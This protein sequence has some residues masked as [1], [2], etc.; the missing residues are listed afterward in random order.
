M[1]L[2]DIEHIVF[3]MLENRSFDHMLG[4]LSLEETPDPLP[5]DGLRSDDAWK[6]STANYT[7][8]GTAHPVN[9]I[10]ADEKISDPPHGHE[11]VPAQIATPVGVPGPRRMGG[12]VQAYIDSRQGESPPRRAGAVMGYYDGNGVWAYDSLARNYCV[13][14]RWFT[15]LPTGTQPNRLMAMGGDTRI[16]ENSGLKIPGHD[17]VYDWL[18]RNGVDWRVYTWGGYPPF[19][20]LMWEWWDDVVASARQRF[21]KFGRLREDWLSGEAVPSLLFIEPK[22]S[23]IP[24]GPANDDHAPTRI[25]GG[26]NLVK[27]LYDI[28]TSNAERWAKTLLIVTYDE[29]GGFFDHVP[30]LPIRKQVAE[31]LFETTGPRVPALLIS[32][33]V[34]PGQVFHEPV[35]HTAFLALLAERFTPGVPYSGAVA[36]RQSS[37]AGFGRLSQALRPSARAGAAPRI[38]RPLAVSALE[39]LE[40]LTGMEPGRMGPMDEAPDADTPTA[41]AFDRAAR[42]TAEMHPDLLV[43]PD[44]DGLAR[45]VATAPPPVVK[46]EDHIGDD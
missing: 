4:Y 31:E 6:D 22:Y 3:L 9:P 34:D 26:Q 27:D 41:A 15:P 25:T 12:F 33:H 28:L 45:Y 5:V 39:S 40:S 20:A 7:R 24:I 37:Y 16:F 35:D 18:N 13:C 44:W 46:H 43:D 2:N 19:F 17:L 14:D 32:P 10:A 11:L 36:E 42:R 21:R 23:E 30:P 29:H 8:D 38:D 1:A